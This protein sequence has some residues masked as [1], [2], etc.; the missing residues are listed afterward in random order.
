MNYDEQATYGRI[1]HNRPTRR[2]QRARGDAEFIWSLRL[3]RPTVRGRVRYPRRAL[4]DQ[5][6]RYTYRVRY[7]SKPHRL[8]H[9]S[10]ANMRAL[11]PR[12]RTQ[13]PRRPREGR[14]NRQNSRHG[15]PRAHEATRAEVVCG[16]WAGRTDCGRKRARAPDPEPALAATHA[17]RRAGGGRDPPKNVPRGVARAAQPAPGDPLNSCERALRRRSCHGSCPGR[18]FI[19]R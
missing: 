6:V 16:S 15:R 14:S 11:S 7:T 4:H 10:T 12:P 17:G 3:V 5:A 2:C 1:E 18:P 19:S 13:A 8:E 9:R